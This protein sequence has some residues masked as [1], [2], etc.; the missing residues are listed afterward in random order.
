MRQ[1]ACPVQS[2]LGRQHH[3]CRRNIAQAKTA[4]RRSALPPRVQSVHRRRKR[5]GRRHR[6]ERSSHRGGRAR[7]Q[8]PRRPGAGG[9]RAG[10]RRRARTRLR[11][12]SRTAITVYGH[13]E[14]RFGGQRLRLRYL[15]PNPVAAA[16]V[17]RPRPNPS[18]WWAE[19]T[20]RVAGIPRGRHGCP[21]SSGAGT[22]GAGG[23]CARESAVTA[24]DPM[25]LVV[26]LPVLPGP[27]CRGRSEA[28]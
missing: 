25:A 4:A 2:G 16:P 3:S 15:V 1:R 7:R 20:E 28:A 26:M 18:P 6:S 11:S 19:R 17:A 23:R 12:A 5:S 24:G 10:R 22:R 14:P 21:R 13:I 9:H 27:P 8:S